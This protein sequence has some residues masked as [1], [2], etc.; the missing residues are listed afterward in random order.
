MFNA[1]ITIH[2][3]ALGNL[4]PPSVVRNVYTSTAR[5]ETPLASTLTVSQILCLVHKIVSW[6]IQ[7]QSYFVQIAHRIKNPNLVDSVHFDHKK[8]REIIYYHFS[9]ITGTIHVKP[10]FHGHSYLFKHVFNE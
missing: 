2:V 9:A 1:V 7:Y 3:L 5:N 10:I 4:Q 6:K 8:D